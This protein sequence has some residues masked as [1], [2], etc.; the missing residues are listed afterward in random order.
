[1]SQANNKATNSVTLDNGLTLLH[2]AMPWLPSVS[3]S[4]LLPVGS[5]TDPEAGSGSATVLN[6]W[7]GR[8]A[9]GRSSREFSDALDTLGIRHGSSADRESTSFSAAMMAEVLDDG[10]RL[11]SDQVRRPALLDAEFEGARELALQELKSLDDQPSARLFD[12]LSRHYFSSEHGRSAYGTEEGLQALT[13]ESVRGYY[14]SRYSP[15]GAILAVAGG[16]SFEEVLDTVTR[17]FADW[18]GPQNLSP[19]VSVARASVQQLEADTAQTQIG[20]VFTVN[21]PTHPDWYLQTLA[22]GVLSG[23]MSARLF[24][25]VREKRG[26]VYSVGA[27]V[28][29]VRGA[30]YLVGYAGTTPERAEETGSVMLH[31]FRRLAEGISQNELERSRAGILSRLVLQ[32]ESS[33]SRARALVGD[34]FLRGTTRTLDEIR[35]AVDAITLDGINSYLER[36]VLQEPTVVTLGPVGTR[37]GAS[38]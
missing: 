5:A 14:A 35:D 7:V 28:N 17:H 8:G 15:H 9:G 4:L 22:V 1:M 37:E 21:P 10:L 20:M 33:G 25:E 16:V 31:E 27:A 30:G 32:G 12:A 2:E 23:G 36:S 26:L 19:E 38:K 13:P 24:D 6:D 29:A 18:T 3:V 34:Q 11:L